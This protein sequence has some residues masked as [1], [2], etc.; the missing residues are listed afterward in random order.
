MRFE[1]HKLTE[2][3]CFQVIIKKDLRFKDASYPKQNQ[4]SLISNYPRP[5]LRPLPYWKT[6]IPS[7]LEGRSFTFK[8]HCFVCHRPTTCT[9]QSH[10][11]QHNTASA[12]ATSQKKEKL[13]RNERK[14]CRCFFVFFFWTACSLLLFAFPCSIGWF[15]PSLGG[16]IVLRQKQKQKPLV[17]ILHKTDFVKAWHRWRVWTKDKGGGGGEIKLFHLCRWQSIAHTNMLA[18]IHRDTRVGGG[19]YQYK[20]GSFFYSTNI[21]GQSWFHCEEGRLVR[22]QELRIPMANSRPRW[23]RWKKT[24]KRRLPSGPSERCLRQKFIYLAILS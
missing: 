20:W 9:H 4:Y 23:R 22:F 14:S 6:K 11:P 2:K 3:K 12:A 21:L 18:Q 16:A 10:P 5:I 13:A 19:W 8:V 24:K 1:D 17:D 15:C 7:Q